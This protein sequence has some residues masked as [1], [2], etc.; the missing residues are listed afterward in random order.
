MEEPKLTSTAYSARERQLDSQ[1]KETQKSG[2]PL[3]TWNPV[4]DIGPVSPNNRVEDIKPLAL[5]T[6]K[7]ESPTPQLKK[8]GIGTWCQVKKSNILWL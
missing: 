1:G 2:C 3:G 6:R 5:V 7:I 4:Y 8:Q